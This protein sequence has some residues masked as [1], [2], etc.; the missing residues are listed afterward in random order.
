MMMQIDSKISGQR[1]DSASQYTYGAVQYS[2]CVR[3][4]QELMELYALSI[5]I[6]KQIHW[7]I[8]FICSPLAITNVCQLFLRYIDKSIKQ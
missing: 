4:L 1:E 7:S 8:I 2:A 3:R 5:N 6:E